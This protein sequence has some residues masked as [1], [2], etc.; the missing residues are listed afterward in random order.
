[1]QK[2]L[3]IGKKIAV[4]GTTGSGKTTFSRKLSAAVNIEHYELDSLFWKPG[5]EESANEEFRGRIKA[6]TDRT[7]WIID[8][9]YA[10]N[11]D[12]TIGRAD[13]V[14]WLDCSKTVSLYRVLKRSLKR[15]VNK[16]RLW[17]DNKE[18]VFRLFS[19]KVSI[20]FFAYRSYINKKNR[21]NKLFAGESHISLVRIKKKRDEK[22]FWKSIIKNPE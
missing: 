16:D 21:Y 19:P 3:H 2:K 1:M 5:W 20:L 6:A 8:G 22:N 4:V 17:Q 11:Q 14:I 12:L 18:T 7:Q 15:I 13:T 10:R 9:N